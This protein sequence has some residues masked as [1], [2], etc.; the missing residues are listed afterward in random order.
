MI[1]NSRPA[2][3]GGR[4]A[5]WIRFVRNPVAGIVL[6][7]L[8][9]IVIDFLGG[10]SLEEIAAVRLGLDIHAIGLSA[11]RFVVYLVLIW[12]GPLWRGVRAGDLD[13]ARIGMCV[14]AA[15]FEL[16]LVQRVFL[17]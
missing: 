13:R 15:T 4:F 17:F 11:V 5:R 12:Y 16:V 1:G 6:L 2:G 3:R 14:A 10:P 8:S 9:P 7:A